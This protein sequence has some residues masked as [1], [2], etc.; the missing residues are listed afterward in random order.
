M[1]NSMNNDSCAAR[2][3]TLAIAGGIVIGLLFWAIMGLILGVLIGLVGWVVLRSLLPKMLCSEGAAAKTSATTT[4][5]AAE[6]APAPAPASEPAA[7]DPV[8]APEAAAETAPEA[9][10]AASGSVVKP[11]KSLPGQEELAA[12]KGTWKYEGGASGTASAQT[13]ATEPAPASADDLKKLKGVGPKLEEKLH[14]AGVTRFAQIAAWGPDDIAAMDEKL[15]FKGRIE[16][17]G[18]IAQA[19]ELSGS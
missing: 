9:A 17:D 4:A 2:C 1:T 14:A 5:P 19:K 13:P 15:S 6:A 8:A 7:E 12:R 16:R 18:W 3:Q 10:P 11:S